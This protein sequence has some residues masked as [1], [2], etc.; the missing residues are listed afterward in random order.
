MSDPGKMLLESLKAKYQADYKIAEATLRVYTSSPVGI[1]EHPQHVEE[2]DK[3]VQ[4]MAD[5]QDKLDV[6]SKIK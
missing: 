5:A 3:L 4:A 1:G 2:M 6:L